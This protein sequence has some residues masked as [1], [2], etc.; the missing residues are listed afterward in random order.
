MLRQAQ[1]LLRQAQLKFLK[2]P[3]CTHIACGALAVV[4]LI[5]IGEVLTPGEA[6][7]DVTR[8]PIVGSGKTPNG[9][10]IQIKFIKF[11]STWQIPIA[12]TV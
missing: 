10:L 11:I 9:R 3:N 5:A 8:T 12:I 6:A 4:A 2:S 7:T 1:Y